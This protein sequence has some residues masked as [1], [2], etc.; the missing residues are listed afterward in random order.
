MISVWGAAWFLPFT[1][2]IGVWVATTDMREMKIPNMAVY[3][4]VLVYLIIGPIALPFQL[5][6]W[7]WLFG[8]IALLIGVFV[9]AAGL[10]GAGDAKFAAAMTPFFVN[11]DLRFTYGLIAAC[12]LGAWATHRLLGII[13]PLRAAMTDW[14]SWRQEGWPLWSKFPMG[15]ALVG[16]INFYLALAIFLQS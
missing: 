15:L 16:M 6:L 9:N 1:F 7:G 10:V 11:A 5:W 4:L 3:A 8:V 13:P 14:Q 2:A 12:I